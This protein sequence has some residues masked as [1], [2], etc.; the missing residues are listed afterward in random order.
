MAFISSNFEQ[1]R[2]PSRAGKITKDNLRSLLGKQFSPALVDEMIA[3]ADF[4]QN[5]VVDYE[6]FKQMMLASKDQRRQE[7]TKKSSP[8][9]QDEISM[10]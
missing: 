8:S 1:H 6:E 10:K 5:G 9:I 7:A 2:S 4:K 3:D